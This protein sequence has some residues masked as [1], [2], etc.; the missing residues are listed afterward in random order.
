MVCSHIT[1]LRA[2]VELSTEKLANN[3]YHLVKGSLRCIGIPS[4]GV[5]TVL[6]E[7]QS[8]GKGNRKHMWESIVSFAVFLQ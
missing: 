3:Q 5:R 4:S 8:E 1:S 6:K 7:T 2:S